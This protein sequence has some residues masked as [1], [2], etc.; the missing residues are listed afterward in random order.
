MDPTRDFDRDP[1][2]HLARHLDTSIGTVSRALNDKADVN[3]LTRARVR[4]AAAKLGYSPKPVG[5]QPAARQDRPRRRHPSDRVG[6]RADKHRISVGARWLAAQASAAGSI[7]IFCTRRTRAVRLAAAL[8]RAWSR[9]WRDH[10]QHAAHRPPDRLSHGGE[11]WLL[12]AAAFRRNCAHPW[13]D[14]GFRGRRR[15]RRRSSRR[16]GA[17]AHR[18]DVAA[19]RDAL[20]PP[21]PRDMAERARSARR[22]NRPGERRPVGEFGGYD[23]GE[24]L[25]ACRLDR[26]PSSFRKLCRRSA[27]IGSSA[28]T[29]FRTRYYACRRDAGGASSSF[30]RG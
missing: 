26:P 25:M 30:R 12:L 11:K 23:A 21:H 29:V 24:A 7:A 22:G 16:A 27:F 2:I 8:D 4:E 15:G 10:R 28:K 18:T 19:R 3:P 5:A 1:G 17:S 14:P 9:R 20:F 13:V 6:Q